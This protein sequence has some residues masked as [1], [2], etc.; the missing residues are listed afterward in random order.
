M[1]VFDGDGFVRQKIYFTPTF[2]G[3]GH[4]GLHCNITRAHFR[5]N[6]EHSRLHV[7]VELKLQCV[8]S[9]IHVDHLVLGPVL[10]HAS[11]TVCP[12]FLEQR[13]LGRDVV[14]GIQYQHLALGFGLGEIAGN[15]TRAL[16]RAG[17]ATVWCKGDG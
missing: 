16:V 9:G 8:G 2:V 14:I 10:N 5:N 11:V 3:S 17:R 12:C 1:H 7:I 13:P 6:V 4:A 15:L